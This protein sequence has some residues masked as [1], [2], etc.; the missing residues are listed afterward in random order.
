MQSDEPNPNPPDP[1]DHVLICS[2][3]PLLTGEPGRL[4][5]V[6]D[7]EFRRVLAEAERCPSGQAD[8]FLWIA[9]TDGIQPVFVLEQADP[10][11]DHLLAWSEGRVGEWFSLCLS[12]RGDR[13]VAALVPNLIRSVGRFEAGNL[14]ATGELSE[15]GGYD[16]LFRP[17][18]FVSRPGHT[19]GQVR[20][21][22]TSPTRVGLL[23][24]T[25]FTSAHPPSLALNRVQSIGP[26]EV[27]WDERPF[28]YDVRTLLDRFVTWAT[29]PDPE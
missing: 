6:Q 15:A 5:R 12:E 11:A 21:L 9:D 26:V 1:T 22:I 14:A 19:F 23:D 18:F 3:V 20:H 27:S 25:A 17:L 8:A 10:I 7:P 28:G 4:I 13:F 16:L 24:A 29:E 2:Y